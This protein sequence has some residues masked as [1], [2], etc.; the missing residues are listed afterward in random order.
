VVE[1]S[2]KFLNF[3]IFDFILMFQR[4]KKKK[5]FKE[6]EKCDQKAI[7]VTNGCRLSVSSVFLC[8]KNDGKKGVA[9][10]GCCCHDGSL[11]T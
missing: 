6:K 9:F 2:K 5:K 10:T 1:C 3:K 7:S 4:I 11:R 8:E